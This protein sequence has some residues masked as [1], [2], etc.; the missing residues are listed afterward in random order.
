MS[1]FVNHETFLKEL[2][3]CK[4]LSI[5]TMSNW[6]IKG[7]TDALNSIE[8]EYKGKGYR[9]WKIKE[10][11]RVIPIG[12]KYNNDEESRRKEII[13]KNFAVEAWNVTINVNEETLIIGWGPVKHLAVWGSFILIFLTICFLIK[14]YLA[15]KEQKEVKKNKT[16][17]ERF[18]L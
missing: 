18:W 10:E 11:Q 8:F 2:T 9:I 12:E 5:Y 17:N 1:N 15:K 16:K 3:H 13:V 7:L 6:N 4:A 14:R